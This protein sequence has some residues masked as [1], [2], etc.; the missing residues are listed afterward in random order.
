MSTSTTRPAIAVNK[1]RTDL[2][3]PIYLAGGQL[4]IHYKDKWD[5]N[6]NDVLTPQDLDAFWRHMVIARKFVESLP[7]TEMEGRNELLSGGAGRRLCFADPGAAYGVYLALGGEVSLDLRGRSGRYRITWVEPTT[8][9]EHDGG[10]I[11]GGDWRELG[12]PPFSG[13]AAARIIRL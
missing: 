10:I 8:G 7:F 2:F 11:R 1:A 4:E 3:W 6:R 13:D 12:A 5:P 9:S